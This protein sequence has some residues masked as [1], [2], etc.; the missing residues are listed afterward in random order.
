MPKN[1][2]PAP[3]WRLGHYGLPALLILLLM[4]NITSAQNWRLIQPA[5]PTTDAIVAAYSVRDDGATGDGVT[6]VTSIFQS[7]LNTLG[8][9]GG[10]TLFVPAGR[11]VIRGALV[12]PRGVTLRGEWKKPVKG[13]AISGTVLMAY[14]GRG[15]ENAASFI[16]MEPTAGVQDLA[17]WYPEQLPD[18]ITPYSPAI[19][20]GRPN[21]WGN[22]FCN[23]RNITLVNTYSGV[24]FSRLNSGSCPI[25]NGLYGTPLSRGV[26]IDNIADV[27]HIEQIDFSP[28]YWAGSGLPNA[29][30]AGSGYAGWIH[31]NGTGIVMRRNDWTYTS[32]VNIDGYK[33]GFHAAPSIASAGAIPNGHNYGMTFSNC[34]TG[35]YCEGVSNVGI[36]FA[37]VNTI[38]CTNG[39]V[40]GS[41]NTDGALQLHTCNLSGSTNAISTQPGCLARIM[42]QQCSFGS[43]KVN[44]AGGT[45]MAS[46][47]DFNNNAPQISLGDKSRGIITGNRFKNTVNIEDNTPYINT[48]DHTPLTLPRL[49]AFS[50]PA[51]RT[52]QPLRRVL[53]LATAAPFNA[54]NDGITDNTSAVQNALDRAFAEGGGVVFL[55]PGKYKF[56]GQLSVPRGVELKGATDNLAAPMGQGTILEP[57]ADRNNPSGTPFIKLA[58][59][60]GIRGLTINYPEQVYANLPNVPAYPYTI[61]GT[62]SDIYI[63]NVG[64]RAAYRGVDLFT[65]K[66]DNHYV[67]GLTGHAF[68]TA[69]KVGAGASGGLIS[70]AQFN[71]IVYAAG[72]E[73]KWGGWP[74]SPAGDNSKAYD[75][76]FNNLDF[77]AMG[78][79]T[80]EV[81]YNNFIYGARHGLVFLQ[82]GN[83]P[84]G[85]SV[86][87]GLDGTRN[88]IS[89]QGLGAGGFDLINSQLVA[90][91]DT[92]YAYIETTP[93]FTSTVTF[94]NSDYWGNPGKSLDMGGSGTLRFQGANFHQPGQRRFATVRNGALSIHNSA[95]WPVNTILNAGAEPRFSA[96][97]SIVDSSNI[98][99]ARAALWKNNQGNA[100]SVSIDGDMDRHG[101]TAT[102][103]IN[104]NNAKNALDSANSTWNTGGPQTN[105]QWFTVDMKTV[106]TVRAVVLDCSLNANDSPAGY[107]LFISNDGVNWGSPIASGTGTTGMTLISFPEKTG[108]YLRVVQTGSRDWWW[109]IQEFHVFGRVNVASVSLDTTSKKLAVGAMHRL[110]AM[111]LP[112]NATI[113]T[114]SWSSSNTGVARV[115]SNGI[116]TA[117][118]PG[119]AVITVTTIDGGKTATCADT[120]LATGNT[121]F[122]GTPA[123]IPGRIE[124]ERYDEG[125]PGIAYADAD[126]INNGS[127]RATESVDVE[128]C[129]EGTYN[130]GW[131]SAG[132]WLKYTVNV[133]TAGV[134]NLQ[135][136]VASPYTGRQLH[137]ELDGVNISG[138][139]TAPNTGDW[140]RY[141]TINVTTPSLSAGRKTLRVVMDTDGFN[142]NYLEF[143]SVTGAAET[144][145]VYP[146]PVT[147]NQINLKLDGHQ[148]GRYRVQLFNSLNQ[149]VMNTVIHAGSGKGTYALPLSRRLTPGYYVVEIIDAKGRREV[150]KVVVQ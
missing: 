28:A 124:A 71:T 73:S 24:I 18:N 17:I 80:G 129:A 55:P 114:L 110:T 56:L 149:P 64:L 145:T 14:T 79:C 61:Q 146:N 127:Y 136:R 82:D 88:A 137:V 113:K 68:N 20:F 100:W 8:T 112:A 103:S 19:T 85:L 60:S 142:I 13:E 131:T 5:F 92:T 6:D 138:T 133:N 63:V 12:I 38:G 115:D 10:G 49:P 1:H 66:C 7:R 41:N 90:V 51:A 44:I 75:Y 81:L 9:I 47:C 50:A 102:A 148:P 108:R 62:G 2:Y 16:T 30:A 140:Q 76:N 83:G 134:Y 89:F 78:N 130:L 42:A 96:Q 126:V 31:A 58:A 132:E 84:S 144:M 104:S 27:G 125:G 94:F 106:N 40:V 139:Q 119:N 54:K 70:N 11:Y 48:I 33:I 128:N 67:E 98:V 116:V 77:M 52:Q 99:P 15:D 135:I 147:G 32:F 37:R 143:T 35:I 25:I 107:D 150:R 4:S 95:V 46:D 93:S 34:S 23:A 39:I 65:Y 21:Y 122:G 87:T 109:T 111:V 141:Q 121:P 118:A 97:S 105:G 117:V 86:G 69:I 123:G 43:G 101:W 53:Y 29:P 59:S 3:S 72:A 36:M 45:F 57:Y 91:G 26:E 74:N 22:E 120:V